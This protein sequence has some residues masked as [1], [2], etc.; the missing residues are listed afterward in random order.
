VWLSVKDVANKLDVSVRTIQ[1]RI[2]KNDFEYR[3]KPGKG[4]SGIQYEIYWKD[5]TITKSNEEKTNQEVKSSI[6]K[7]NIKT[8]NIP[9]KLKNSNINAMRK[10]TP[11]FLTDFFGEPEPEVPDKYKRIGQLRAQ[12]CLYTMKLR[13]HYSAEESYKLAVFEYNYTELGENLRILW[14]PDEVI[15]E[16]TLRRW[17]SIFKKHKDYLD[18]VPGYYTGSGVHTITEDE[19][20]FLLRW[21]LTPNQV[22]IGT[23]IKKLKE[24]AERGELESPTSTRT[25]RRW[26]ERYKKDHIKVVTLMRKGEKYLQDNIIKHIERD[27]KAL[28][29]GDVWIADGNVLNFQIINPLTGK[30]QRMVFVPWLDWRSR[31]IVGG[32]IAPTEDTMNIA[33]A[34]RNAVLNWGGTPRAVYI[35]NGRAFKSK[36]FTKKK[37]VN[38]ENELGGLFVKLN[39][40]EHFA[41][42][43]NAKAKPIERWFRTFNDNFERFLEQYRGASISDQPANLN[44]NEKWLQKLNHG[45][46]FTLHEAQVLIAHYIKQI[47]HK[48]PH[49][50]LGNKT[51]EEIYN[52]N[53]CPE[54][55]KINPGDLNYLML[56]GGKKKVGPNGIRHNKINY[57]HPKMVDLVG[58]YIVFRYDWHD[59]RYVQIYYENKLFCTAEMNQQHHPMISLDPNKAIS[60]KQLHHELK[61]Q[62]KTMKITKQLAKAELDRVM[63]IN[64]KVAK[65]HSMNSISS[66]ENSELLK[67]PEKKKTLDERIAAVHSKIFQK[68]RQQIDDEPKNNNETKEEKSKKT[69]EELIKRLKEGVI[70]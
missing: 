67:P 5:E 62:R 25:L 20:K 30:P 16:R 43:Y 3:L 38:L 36:Y 12:I 46:P 11:S 44:R 14:P 29:V 9:N 35:D 33:S 23:I 45:E 7:E 21:Y 49:K 18:L 51:P 6:D 59:L 27:D 65:V 2:K 13:E 56:K 64:R 48:S 41:K 69:V 52:S 39:V 63:D 50:G 53:L 31:Y 54:N 61:Q 26:L 10:S 68:E 55:R 15:S 66:I 60:E 19:E 28:E 32:S 8:E 22:S 1:R 42:P 58:Q 37:D 17:I 47:Y 70:I 40:E 34:F 24:C 57:W 4:R